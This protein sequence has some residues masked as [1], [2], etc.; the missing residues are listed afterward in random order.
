MNAL[1]AIIRK[2]SI[3]LADLDS[4]FLVLS[5]DLIN[6]CL[7]YFPGSLKTLTT[8]TSSSPSLRSFVDFFAYN[9]K[10]FWCE[11]ALSILSAA[12]N[13]TLFTFFNKHFWVTPWFVSVIHTFWAKLNWNP[14]IHF[15]VTAWW[16]TTDWPFNTWISTSGKYFHYYHFKSIRR[17]I[18]AKH[19]RSYSS[20]HFPD[21]RYQLFSEKINQCFSKDWCVFLSKRKATNSRILI[22]YL[23]RYIARPII[24]VSRISSYDWNN[25]TFNYFDKTHKVE[26]SCT[27]SAPDFL[28]RL[29]RHIPDH[30]LKYVRYWWVFANRCKSKY[31][32][33]INNVWTNTS[34]NKKHFM[35]FSYAERLRRTY[36]INP[37]VCPCW[38]FFR[39]ISITYRGQVYCD[40]W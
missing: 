21:S 29:A 40:S 38:W 6:E 2:W 5:L 11:D 3:L 24:W 26:S 7:T 39:L 25:I 20:Q 16:I 32:P 22:W 8:I 18:L 37:A 19:L 15:I 1:V 17:A 36:W 28:G 4:V 27:L 14:H 33:I 13:E 9:R 10:W 23:W 34:V 35:P 12:A 30:H 31:L